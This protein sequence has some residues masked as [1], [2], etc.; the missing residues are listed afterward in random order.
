[1]LYQTSNPLNVIP[2]LSPP[3]KVH[4]N[5]FDN[6]KTHNLQCGMMKYKETMIKWCIKIKCKFKNKVHSNTCL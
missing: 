6:N 2:H 3:H 5:R 4:K 1:M